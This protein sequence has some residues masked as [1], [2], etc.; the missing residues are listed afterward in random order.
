MK[1]FTKFHICI[2][3]N[4]RPLLTQSLSSLVPRL[5]PPPVCSMQKQ[6]GKAWEKMSHAWCQVDRHE[7]RR[8]DGGVPNHCNSQTLHWSAL[9]LPNNVLTLSFEVTVSSSWTKY[10][11]TSTFFVRHH[12]P[13]VFPLTSCTRLFLLGLSHILQGIKK[14]EV[15][16]AWE[17][18]YKHI[19][20]LCLF[21]IWA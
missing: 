9:N 6:R 21:K 5:F 13:H 2:I 11:K 14:L 19:V 3:L 17:R 15:E 16:P 1:L 12:P 8:E 4:G 18:N 10:Y 7:G 20:F